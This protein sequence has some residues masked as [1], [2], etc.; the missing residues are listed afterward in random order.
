MR[1]WPRLRGRGLWG[2]G[3]PPRDVANMSA[4]ARAGGQASPEAF[5]AELEAVRPGIHLGLGKS[6][7]LLA[8]VGCPQKTLRV[9]HVAG[10]NGKGSVCAMVA[11]ALRA[12]GKRVGVYNSP[13]LFH[14]SDAVLVDGEPD[15]AGWRAS[16]G[17]IQAA[18]GDVDGARGRYTAFEASCAAMWLQLATAKV[19]YAVIEAGVGGLRDATNVCDNVS[20]SV[21]TSVG[22]DHQQLLGDTI[23]KIAQDKCGIFKPRCPAVVSSVVPAE[24][25]SVARATAAHQDSPLIVA[26]PATRVHAD[27]AGCDQGRLRWRGAD[28]GPGGD[29]GGGELEFELRLMG[30]VQLINA[31]VAAGVLRQLQRTDTSLTDDHLRQ[32]LATARWPGRMEPSQWM[33]TDMLLDGA[34]NPEAALALGAYM[35]TLRVR[36][37]VAGVHWIIGMSAGK[38]VEGVVRGLVRPGDVVGCVPVESLPQRYETASPSRILQ[39]AQAA[40]ATGREHPCLRDALVFAV[41]RCGGTGGGGGGGGGTGVQLVLCGSLH[42]V[43]DFRRLKASD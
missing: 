28:S 16:M 9:V 40:G 2:R 14:W 21:L 8:R 38:D 6:L 12:A 42:L 5:L 23:A 39:V 37:E 24:A 35:D 17:A 29:V 25:M 43:A 15:E 4:S 31:G 11:A 27:R 3:T 18:L 19:D 13:H 22:L 10:T 26:P 41:E 32:G 30:D 36:K 20:A 33:G 7:E 34:H 1:F